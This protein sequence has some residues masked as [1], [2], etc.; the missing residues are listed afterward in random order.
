M[1]EETEHIALCLR[2]S[3]CSL[4][5]AIWMHMGCGLRYVINPIPWE[6]NPN[7]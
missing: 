7:G 3:W 5:Y 1:P 2:V 6:S 4:Y